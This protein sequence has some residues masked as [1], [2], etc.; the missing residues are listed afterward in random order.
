[1]KTNQRTYWDDDQP[2]SRTLAKACLG[3]C[4]KILGQ[5]EKVK[6]A[7]VA[8]FQETV[9]ANGKLVRLALNEAEA[10]AAQTE[11]PHL[12]FPVLATEKLQAVRTWSARQQAVRDQAGSRWNPMFSV[13]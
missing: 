1:M 8:E 6:Q 5:I 9:S 11:Y 10:L 12:L 3:A 2:Q 7:L 4:Q 13:G